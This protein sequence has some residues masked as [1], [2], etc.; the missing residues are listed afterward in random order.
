MKHI[1]TNWDYSKLAKN[2]DHRAEYDSSIVKKILNSLKCKKNFPVADIG[3]GT[4]KLTKQLLKHNLIVSAVEPNLNMRKFGI[5]NCKN[6]EKINWSA[7]TAEKTGLFENSLYAVFFGSSF[8]VV[9]YK[10]VFKELKR[11][12]I[13]NGF[14]CCLWNHRDLEDP[15]Q[16]KI[17]N[18][19]KKYIKNYNYGERRSNVIPIL[20]RS[21]LFKKIKYLDKKFYHSTLKKII[22]KHGNLMELLKDNQTVISKRLFMKFQKKLIKMT[23]SL[24]KCHLKQLHILLN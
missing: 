10:K 7:A 13:K 8:N 22:L 11:I 14:F 21:N 12:L 16:K 6:Y 15:L 18:I 23:K 4:G 2:Y 24:S 1:K 17:E 20:E 3:A 5:K 9:E 19:I